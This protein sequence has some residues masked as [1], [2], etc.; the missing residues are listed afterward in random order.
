MRRVCVLLCA[1]VA[2]AV[3]PAMGQSFARVDAWR[4]APLLQVTGCNY[5]D[6]TGKI[7]KTNGFA[8]YTWA[9]GDKAVVTAGTQSATIFVLL[10]QYTITAATAN[11]IT[12]SGGLSFV[13][14]ADGDVTNDSI[15]VNICR[16]T[17]RY[18][19]DARGS[20][21]SSFDPIFAFWT[22]GQ[23]ANIMTTYVDNNGGLWTGA[24]L[25]IN[26]VFS[27]YTEGGASGTSFRYPTPNIST[28]LYC[29]SDVS[30][31]NVTLKTSTDG[32]NYPL[33][34]WDSN[35]KYTFAIERTGGL[36]WGAAANSKGAMDTTLTRSAAGELTTESLVTTGRILAQGGYRVDETGGAAAVSG[37]AT[38]V[39]GTKTVNT[40]A[41]T[42]NSR[43]SLSIQSLGTVAAPKAIA[44]TARTASTSFT[45]TSA[46]NTDTSRVF[47]Q[48]HE[49]VQET[50][51]KPTSPSWNSGHSLGADLVC[52][53]LFTEGSGTTLADATGQ[54]GTATL[55]NVTWTTDGNFGPVGVFNGG[56]STVTLPSLTGSFASN[57]ATV[58]YVLK[59]DEST[60]ASTAY[61]GLDSW[62]ATQANHYPY[63][64]GKLYLGEMRSTRLTSFTNSFDRATWHRIGWTHK[65]GASNYV[66]YQNG[67]SIQTAAGEA[68]INVPATIYV[69][70][71]AGP[72]GGSYN[73]KGRVATIL[74]W[75]RALSGAEMAALETD[76]WQMF[77]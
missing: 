50:D 52:A 69:G 34:I 66:I 58:L 22:G 47:W 31:P 57:E 21:S 32:N 33:L 17:Y 73:L 45:I 72:A 67:S 2:V 46:D 64:D 65:N 10:N 26:P 42:A 6:S 49:P 60:P 1:V 48:I 7:T 70:A 61:T 71:N 39:A 12:I 77:R 19:V 27:Q 20:K 38:L 54:L 74:I 75:D 23:G 11:D 4:P 37:V 44:V 8:N 43:I 36:T 51:V 41:V 25:N 14:G 68:S 35:E 62:Y 15:S 76:V 59:L 5:T 18:D 24:Y 29:Y 16:N 40:S 55:T 3:C 13:G 56:T 28:M 30:G 9:S 63:T 53:Y